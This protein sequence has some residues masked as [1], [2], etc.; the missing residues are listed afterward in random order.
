VARELAEEEDI[1]AEDLDVYL[2]EV[3][4]RVILQ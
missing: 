3:G 4:D 1:G 2:E